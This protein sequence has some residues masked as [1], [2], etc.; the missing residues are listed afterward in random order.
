MRSST[1]T[2]LATHQVVATCRSRWVEG[3]M[4]AVLEALLARK[5]E[6]K[7][8]CGLT[9]EMIC[10]IRTS[11]WRRVGVSSFI[12]TMDRVRARSLQRGARRHHLPHLTRRAL[13]PSPFPLAPP[14]IHAVN[15]FESMITF[16]E[17]HTDRWVTWSLLRTFN[18][19][20]KIARTRK[21]GGLVRVDPKLLPHEW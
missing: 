8:G 9:R 3:G 11:C 15:H 16:L 21:D 5:G 7:L 20:F 19:L 6:C 13:P 14:H 18:D 12:S 2:T 10:G 17:T 1:L 4:E